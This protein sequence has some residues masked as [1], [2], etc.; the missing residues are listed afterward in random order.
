MASARAKPDLRTVTIAIVRDGAEVQ[1]MRSKL[2]AAGI[3][4]LLTSERSYALK[5]S[6]DLRAQHQPQLL[7]PEAHGALGKEAG[8]VKLQ[9]GRAD[10][11]RALS[12]LGAQNVAPVPGSSLEVARPKTAKASSRPL[13]DR[14]P[15]V[16][17]IL[18]VFTLLAA[19]LLSI[20]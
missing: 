5:K 15:T 18:V 13:K 1:A 17:I 19:L 11:Q 2:A 20:S 14:D 4:S 16:P 10:V 7:H 12:I 6:Q 9:V 8:A 3:E